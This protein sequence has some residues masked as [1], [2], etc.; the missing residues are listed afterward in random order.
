MLKNPPDSK[1]TLGFSG[2]EKQYFSWFWHKE[3][4][5]SC[6]RN[7][8]AISLHAENFLFSSFQNSD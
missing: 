1:K 8:F 6:A 7:C 4:L 2:P 3:I 5:I